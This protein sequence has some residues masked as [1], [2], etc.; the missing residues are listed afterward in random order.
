MPDCP[1]NYD[2]IIL[3]SV[4]YIII[5]ISWGIICPHPITFETHLRY[6]DINHFFKISHATWIET[7]RQDVGSGL[8]Y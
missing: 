3:S 5:T 2:W 1:V 4:F 6:N 7:Y 8:L